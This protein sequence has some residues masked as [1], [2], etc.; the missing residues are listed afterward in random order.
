M[1]PRIRY[2]KADLDFPAL[3]NIKNIIFLI[4]KLKVVRSAS[5]IP[6]CKIPSFLL[7]EE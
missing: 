6:G 4:L 3:I 1:C 7:I 2:F 5:E